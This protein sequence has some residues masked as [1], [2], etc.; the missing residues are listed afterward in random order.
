MTREQFLNFVRQPD[1]VA[2]YSA[3]ELQKLVDQFPY[4]QPL[5]ILQLRHLKDNDS[6]QYS[7]K[8]KV[9]AAFAPDRVRLY[10]I[11]HNQTVEASIENDIV[12][13]SI[14]P[15]EGNKS[16]AQ[17][18]A[19]NQLSTPANEVEQVVLVPEHKDPL[20][21]LIKEAITESQ[22]KESD[23]FTEIG[24]SDDD[25]HNTIALDHEIRKI[26]HEIK[27][28]E[29]KISEVEQQLSSDEEK[30]FEEEEEEEIISNT[31]AQ[32]QSIEPTST[33]EVQSPIY[34]NTNEENMNTEEPAPK[35]II[36][37]VAP[38]APNENEAHSFAEWL[39]LNH[40]KAK[41]EA[42]VNAIA[43]AAITLEQKKET[44]LPIT[45]ITHES[46]EEIPSERS[47]YE[48]AYAIEASEQ[49]PTESPEENAEETIKSVAKVLYVK[50]SVTE[51]IAEQ[52]NN[53]EDQRAPAREVYLRPNPQH[54]KPA[55]HQNPTLSSI[56][57]NNGPTLRT[58]HELGLKE[59][60]KPS[61]KSKKVKS[62]SDYKPVFSDKKQPGKNE[63]IQ[64][65]EQFIQ[66]AP[67]ITP[68][69][70]YNNPVNMARKSVQESDE[71]ITETLAAIYAQ[72]GNFEKAI[73]FY[74]KLSLKIPE[75]SAY[76]ASL[77]KDLKNKL[78]S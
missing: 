14:E 34:S 62:P 52:R 9:T 69:K 22:I 45:V 50:G 13:V 27:V 1:L 56:E 15:A 17:E 73:S 39:Q 35:E 58:N 2:T 37:T 26:E 77:I 18:I 64:I 44:A 68:M 51:P 30:M 66:Q 33:E 57:R 54:I 23:Y 25:G 31:I 78:N 28:V 3:D 7:Q 74:E 24:L 53:L 47:F 46:A 21:D 38:I 32:E 48:P 16:I 60:M 41:D 55:E 4:C 10:Q 59:V 8:L 40:S 42:A 29:F 12:E 71:L 36:A 70:A 75:K 6:I 49:H 61:K 43:P 76:F 5:R 67:R 11:M 20:E 72:Q 65:I 63:Q 19:E